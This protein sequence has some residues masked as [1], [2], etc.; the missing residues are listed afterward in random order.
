MRAIDPLSARNLLIRLVGIPSVT[1]HESE[2]CTYLAQAL[3]FYGWE[4]AHIDE[5]GNVVAEKGR[6]P[7]EL[8]LLG[9]IDTV[10][11]GPAVRLEGDILWGRGSVDAK[12]PL[13]TFAVGGGAAKVPDGWK[14][15]LIAAVGEEGDSRG[16]LHILP[17]HS[18]AGCLIGEPSHTDGITI[19]YRGYIRL[20]IQAGDSGAHRSGDAGPITACV[21][22][23][24]DILDLVDGRD[25]HEKP[26]IERPSAAIIGMFG[27]E[28]GDRTGIIDMDIRL[29]VGAGVDA[30]TED[31]KRFSEKR[32]VSIRSLSSMP[33][34]LT[35]KNNPMARTL[36][37]AVRDAGLKP[38]VLAKGGTADFNLAAA[39]N[40][41]MAA[42]GPGD[43][44][45]DHTANEHLDLTEYLTAAEIMKKALENFMEKA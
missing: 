44:K 9:H 2:A 40:C 17:R 10:A 7:R 30:W 45:L 32:G 16:A 42:Y 5:I 20:K 18:P 34:H 39:W 27:K 19:G 43:S 29:P 36:R 31:V 37:L 38:R 4:S 26:V 12:G 8:L 28:D 11:G 6:G 23:A 22:A 14:L 3:P 25:D 13:C 15:T 33:A 21:R 41:P 35:D 24:A 1:R